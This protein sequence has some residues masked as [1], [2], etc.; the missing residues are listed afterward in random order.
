MWHVLTGS[1]SSG[2]STLI[3]ALS[4]LGYTT[5]HDAG[6][7]LI[8]QALAKGKSL[9]QVG[10]DSPK[11]EMTCARSQYAAE[12]KLDEKKIAFLDRAVPDSLGYFI[13][14]GW[15]VPPELSKL[16]ATHSYGKIF[17]LEL[18]DYDKDYARVESPETALAMQ[19]CFK[20]AYQQL[21]YEVITIPRDSVENRLKLI[22]SY[23]RD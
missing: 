23:I 4:D 1:P 19:G 21:G 12:H 6:R 7:E 14:Y 10:V 15:P 5:T 11:F 18:L 2:K 17:L 13:H 22:L 20:K 9:E 3:S 8:D 16:L